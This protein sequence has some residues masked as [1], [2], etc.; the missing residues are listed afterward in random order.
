[1]KHIIV[2]IDFSKESLHGL[3][4]ALV[5]SEK[6]VSNIQMVY[7]QKKSSDYFPGSRKEESK[8]A[9][10]KF[11]KIISDYK[12]MLSEKSKLSY[13][14]KKGKVYEEVVNQAQA[15]K[16]S[17]IISS[18]HG[19]SGFEELFIG[20][21]TFKIISATERP[22]ITI[23]HGTYSDYI[24]RIVLPIDSSVESRQKVLMTAEIAKIFNSVIH[25]VC[26]T[27]SKG[28]HIKNKLN[29]YSKQVCDYLKE[30]KIQY[31]TKFLIGDNIVDLTILYAKSIK[32]DLISIMTEQGKS[33]S[34]LLLGSYAHQM[35]NKAPCPVLCITPKEF[36]IPGSFKTLG[37]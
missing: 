5:L 33:I 20:S 37:G 1:M 13:I 9:K 18:T 29:A 32:A 3:R 17:M 12:K 25:V 28:K 22:V 16:D 8:Y 11:E 7:V 24:S 36:L 27:S 15:F 26:V 35:L 10:K 19:G 34:Y 30:Q 21:N 4:L 14:I 2:P 23:R 6:I 31:T